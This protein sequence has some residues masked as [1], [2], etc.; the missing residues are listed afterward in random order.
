MLAK[1]KELFEQLARL[2]T[3][4]SNPASSAIDSC[5]IDEIVR[6]MNSEDKN[7]AAAVEAQRPYIARAVEIVVKSLRSGGRLIYIGAGTSGRLGVLDAVEC[8]PTFGIDATTVQGLIAGGTKAMF[9]SQE[10]AED[11]EINGSRDIDKLR[12][13]EKDV[14]C[15]IAA[16]L[17]TPY[18]IGGVKR[19]KQRGAQ[20]LFLTTN[21]RT[22]LE[23][24]EF[25]RLAGAIDVAIC[26][27][28]GPEVISGS[29]RLKSG[30]AQKLVLNTITT[31]AMIRLGKVYGNYMV[32]LQSTNAKLR[33]RA[34]RIVM[35]LAGVSYEEASSQLV[36]AGGNVKT[37]LVMIR[38][39]VSA[40]EA[41]KRLANAAGFVRAAIEGKRCPEP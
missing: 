35:T 18:V 37:A 27:E 21:P 34:K 32:D 17:R 6:I 36:K 25:K 12:V 24:P 15:G 9:R 5:S 1:R 26:P 13:A 16:S 30:T 19:A 7:V 33:E 31:A 8:P 23:L 10:G 28:V 11:K 20:T 41:R 3:E 14:V 22:N 40:A 38:A 39:S 2:M 29:T 4:Q